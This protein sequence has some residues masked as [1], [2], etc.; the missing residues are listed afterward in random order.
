MNQGLINVASAECDDAVEAWE[1]ICSS[2]AKFHHIFLF[3]DFDGTL[4]EF[5]AVPSAATVDLKTKEA[6]RRL[7][8]EKQITVSV[9]SLAHSAPRARQMRTPLP[10][11]L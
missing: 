6:L 1:Q 7:A 11:A 5:T 2:L 8:R 10:A 9:L 3:I 4:S